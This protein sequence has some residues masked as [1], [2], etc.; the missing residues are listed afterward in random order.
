VTWAI[1]D[2]NSQRYLIRNLLEDNVCI[3]VLQHTLFG[4]RI[5]PASSFLLARL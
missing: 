2:I 5:V 4:M 1:R 3:N